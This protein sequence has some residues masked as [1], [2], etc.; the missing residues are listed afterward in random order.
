MNVSALEMDTNM[1]T[2]PKIKIWHFTKGLRFLILLTIIF[3]G[4][5]IFLEVMTPRYVQNI[6]NVISLDKWE[7]NLTRQ[8]AIYHNA[9]YLFLFILLTLV[10]SV[11]VQ[12]FLISKI[13][14]EFSINIKNKLFEQIQNFSPQDL[15]HYSVGTV[16]NRLNNDVG[17]MERTL[18]LSVTSIVRSVFMFSSALYFSLNESRQ[19]SYVFLISIPICFVMFGIIFVVRKTVKKLFR[20][21]DEFNQKLQENLHSIKTIKANVTEEY[22]YQKIKQH[23]AKLTKSNLKIVLANSLG[24]SAFMSVIYI[25][26]ILLAT[27]GVNLF[28]EDKIDVG[29]IVLFGTYIWMITASFLGILHISYNIF[30]AIPSSKRLKEILNHEVK[31]TNIPNAIKD[32]EI[33]KIEFKNVSF[34]YDKNPQNTLSNLNFVIDKNTS[35][36]II[37]QTGE[38]KS[39]LVNLLARFYD[40]TEG[41]ILINDINIKQYDLDTLRQKI[42]IVFQE[43]ILFSGTIR[44]NFKLVKHDANDQ[45]IYQVLQKAQIY[46]FIYNSP[47]QLET[48]VNQKGSNFSGGQRQRLAIA[49]AL[50]KDPNLLILDDATSALDFKTEQQVKDTLRQINH[51]IKIIISQKINSIKDCN[52]IIVLERGKIASIGKHQDLLKTSELY[53]KIYKYQNSIL[54]S[55]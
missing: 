45:E 40:V 33:Q 17:S 42:S 2:K 8:Q 22:E 44:S 24:E 14:T 31:I 43:N 4:G 28:L 34:K 15:N 54:E 48:K 18:S 20:Y 25:S 16:L 5:Q 19:L 52:K 6:I 36:G 3:I 39:T 55:F 10:I 13:S 27:I 47:D 11:F 9:G 37:G 23:T 50:I 26:L 53:H 29:H 21:N 1:N 35:L 7:S 38:G 12:I 51:S 49:R 32:F 41:E 30:I 46:D